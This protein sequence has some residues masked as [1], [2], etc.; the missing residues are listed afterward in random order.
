[1]GDIFDFSTPERVAT[2]YDRT[3]KGVDAAFGALRDFRR[4][5]PKEIGISYDEWNLWFAWHHEE[6]IIEGL[7]TA[8]MLNRLMRNWQS[9]EVEAKKVGQNG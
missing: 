9:L 1:M 3:D 4:R 7:Y 5:V 6:G 2:L 8:K